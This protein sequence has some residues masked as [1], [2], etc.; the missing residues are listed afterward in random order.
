MISR[1]CVSSRQKNKGI[2]DRL[3]NS[4]ALTQNTSATSGGG[5]TAGG[6]KTS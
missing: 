4:T 2:I 1:W 3:G 5:V 6:K